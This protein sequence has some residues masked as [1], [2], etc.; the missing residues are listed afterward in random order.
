[1]FICKRKRHDGNPRLEYHARFSFFDSRFDLSCEETSGCLLFTRKMVKNSFCWYMEISH[2]MVISCKGFTPDSVST[3]NWFKTT[4]ITSRSLGVTRP[5]K[6][7]PRTRRANEHDVAHL[8]AKTAPMNLS[9]SESA[10]WLLSYS[11]RCNV[12]KAG[13]RAEADG[14]PHGFSTYHY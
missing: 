13:V 9:C 10:Q 8:Q 2:V 12:V 7:V 5:V 4:Y 6:K 14:F 11:V 3:C 1:M